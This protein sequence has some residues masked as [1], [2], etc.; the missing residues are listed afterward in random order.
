MGNRCWKCAYYDDKEDKCDLA[1]LEFEFGGQNCKDYIKMKC[2]NCGSED[3]ECHG[4]DAERL[5]CL[6]NKC[7]YE[8]IIWGED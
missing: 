3:V 7:G 4:L 1:N 6:C 8:W 5:A 2:P